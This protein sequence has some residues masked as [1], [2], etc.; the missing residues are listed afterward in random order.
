M[1]NKI[2]RNVFFALA[3]AL[4]AP[5]AAAE[6]QIERSLDEVSAAAIEE[7]QTEGTL[8][9]KI[10]DL[11]QEKILMQLEK[12]R[13]Q[14][15]LELDRLAAEKIKLHMEMDTLSGRAEERQAALDVEREK[16][17]AERAK[18]ERERQSALSPDLEPRKQELKKEDTPAESVAEKYALIDIIGAG[19]QLQATVRDLDNGQRKKVSVGRELDGYVVKSISLDDGVVFAKDGAT[20]TLN[21]GKGK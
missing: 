12:E 11:E 8:F 16:L 5:P 7:Y 13:A 1:Q 9:Q 3:A 6:D 19:R 14:L 10:T 15:D 21:V 4:A 18:L 2:F 17:E 20:E